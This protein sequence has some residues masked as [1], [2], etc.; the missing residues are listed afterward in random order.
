MR[1]LFF[2]L[3]FS[4]ADQGLGDRREGEDNLFGFGTPE[5][6][7]AKGQT[8]LHR[9]DGTARPRVGRGAEVDGCGKEGRAA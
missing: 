5:V 4:A 6:R 7:V 3:V 2:S 1:M 8:R 9:M